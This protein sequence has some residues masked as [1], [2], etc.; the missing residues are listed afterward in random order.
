MTAA[1]VVVVGGRHCCQLSSAGLRRLPS[2]HG[3]T[4]Q[5]YE[6]DRCQFEDRRY[7][8]GAIY[9]DSVWDNDSRGEE[10]QQTEV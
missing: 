5:G 10:T 6:T 9:S 8:N 2:K 7:S 1:V 4:P 3:S